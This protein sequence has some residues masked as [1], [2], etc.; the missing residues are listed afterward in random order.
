MAAVHG[1][2][3]A[4]LGNG[5]DL[6]SFLNSASWTGSRDKSE[7]TTFGKT[8]KT[9]I[10]GL[11]DLSVS[12][13][14]IFDGVVGADD[15][16]FTQVFFAGTKTYWSYVPAGCTV[17]ASFGNPAYS[18]D[19]IQ[20]EYAINTDVGNVS[21]I[22]AKLDMSDEGGMV[23]G[24]VY[25]PFNNSTSPTASID[26]VVTS[27]TNGAYLSVH[28]TAATSLVVTANDSADNSSFAAIAG[29]SIS[30]A[31]GRSS[32]RLFLPGTIRRYT[33]IS[34]TGTGTFVAILS[35]V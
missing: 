17:A 21:S 2:N 12:L 6:S 9:Y 8:S 1:S 10:P 20:S 7:T 26:G 19:A 22:T 24:F 27:T 35:R 30:V 11:K 15:D 31:S 33:R 18:W 29:G 14:G 16:I 3:A 32:Q 4:V 28:A 34:F 13:A 23:R 25:S 5:Y